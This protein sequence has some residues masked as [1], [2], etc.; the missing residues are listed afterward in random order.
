MCE[1]DSKAGKG[2]ETEKREA[3][4]L[5]RECSPAGCPLLLKE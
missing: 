3:V 2:R 4:S 5:L 1:K